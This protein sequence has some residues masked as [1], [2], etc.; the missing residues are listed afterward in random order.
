MD[1]KTTT[2]AKART[3]QTMTLTDNTTAMFAGTVNTGAMVSTTVTEKL[4]EPVLFAASVAVHSTGVVPI[5]NV[6]PLAGVQVGGSDPST[7]SFALAL[8]VNTAPAALVAC[9]VAFAGTVT[10]GA[11]LSSTVTVKLDVAV[12]FDESVDV[13]TIVVTPK[14]NDAGEAASGD[15]LT[16]HDTVTGTPSSASTASLTERLY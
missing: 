11:M 2:A 1:G 10:T 8:N 15:P 4:A 7:L 5:W 12:L 13:Q 9:T 3:N 16:V 14:P 6:E